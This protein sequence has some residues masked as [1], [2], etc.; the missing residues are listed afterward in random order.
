MARIDKYL[1]AVRLFK[2]R[3]IAADMV[4][5]GKA[6][7]NGEVVKASREVKVGDQISIKKNTALFTYEVIDLLEKRVGAKLVADY[8]RDITP[9][10]E[11]EK[12]KE[13]L[14]AQQT[15]RESGFGKP[16]KKDKRSI[17]KFLED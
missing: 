12:Y 4:K 8:L 3:S 1:W 14:L 11:V 10:E 17:K 9:K 15:Y 5:T 2:T 13:Y 16:T 6:M 7:V